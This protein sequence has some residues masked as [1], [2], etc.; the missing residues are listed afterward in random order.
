MSGRVLPSSSSVRAPEPIFVDVNQMSGVN[1]RFI[2]TDSFSDG[3]PLVIPIKP[4]KPIFSGHTTLITSPDIIDAFLRY[5]I[6]RAET[7]VRDRDD[8]LDVDVRRASIDYRVLIYWT[9][10]IFAEILKKI[11]VPILPDIISKRYA[12]RYKPAEISKGSQLLSDML[13]PHATDF[14]SGLEYLRSEHQLATRDA[15]RE[16][17][18]YILT[19]PG[20]S[21]RE[22]VAQPERVDSYSDLTTEVVRDL[23][24]RYGLGYEQMEHIVEDVASDV[25]AELER[26]VALVE[27]IHRALPN[28][29]L[30]G[31]LAVRN[32]D[33]S[34]TQTRRDISRLRGKLKRAYGDLTRTV[35][36]VLTRELRVVV[37]QTRSK[38]VVPDEVHLNF[39]DVEVTIPFKD[40]P[41]EARLETIAT[42]LEEWD[43]ININ[44]REKGHM[45]LAEAEYLDSLGSRIPLFAR[46]KGLSSGGLLET[47]R[48]SEMGESLFVRAL[49][50]ANPDS[51]GLRRFLAR[52]TE[53]P[54]R[55]AAF[56][57]VG[58]PGVKVAVWGPSSVSSYGNLAIYERGTGNGSHDHIGPF[59]FYEG[60]FYEIAGSECR[61]VEPVMIRV[62]RRGAAGAIT[63]SEMRGLKQLRQELRSS[64][65]GKEGGSAVARL[66]RL[67]F[68]DIVSAWRGVKWRDSKVK[69]VVGQRVSRTVRSGERAIRIAEPAYELV[70]LL[71]Q[72]SRQLLDVHQYDAQFD[73][74]RFESN[75]RDTLSGITTQ[76]EPFFTGGTS[77]TN[78]RVLFRR[79]MQDLADAIVSGNESAAQINRDV[80]RG[81]AID[82][83]DHKLRGRYRGNKGN[84]STTSAGMEADGWLEVL[85]KGGVDAVSLDRL[86]E[87]ALYRFNQDKAPSFDRAR[88]SFVTGNYLEALH[89]FGRLSIDGGVDV[90]TRIEALTQ[91]YKTANFAQR[92]IWMQKSLREIAH[93]LETQGV[94][95]T[96]SQRSVLNDALYLEVAGIVDIPLYLKMRL[97]EGQKVLGL[98]GAVIT[99]ETALLGKKPPRML[100]FHEDRHS[101]LSDVSSRNLDSLIVGARAQ[102]LLVIDSDFLRTV[103]TLTEVEF[104]NLMAERSFGEKVS[105]GLK[106][107]YERARIIVRKHGYSPAKLQEHPSVKQIARRIVRVSRGSKRKA[108][109]SEMGLDP[110]SGE[111]YVYVEPRTLTRWPLLYDL[112]EAA[113]PTLV[114]LLTF[115][116]SRNIMTWAYGK[117][118]TLM[119]A[120]AMQYNIL[121]GAMVLDHGIAFGVEKY[122]SWR[123][124]ITA[125]VQPIIMPQSFSFGELGSGLGQAIFISRVIE[126]GAEHVI[127][128]EPLNAQMVGL[129]GM[130]AVLGGFRPVLKAANPKAYTDLLIARRMPELVKAGKYGCIYPESAPYVYGGAILK[131]AAL[132][133]A[134]IEFGI[135]GIDA[136]VDL[137]HDDIERRVRM[138]ESRLFIHNIRDQSFFGENTTGASVPLRLFQTLQTMIAA[139]TP[140]EAWA[141]LVGDVVGSEWR[142]WGEAKIHD[143]IY[144]AHLDNTKKLAEYV[145]NAFEQS[146]AV[147]ISNFLLDPDPP[148]MTE[149]ISWLP[150]I[151]GEQNSANLY[152]DN[153]YSY[154]SEYL[155]PEDRH[156]L[157][158]KD[159]VT[160]NDINDKCA[161]VYWLYDRFKLIIEEMRGILDR[162]A[163]HNIKQEMTY[164]LDRYEAELKAMH[165]F[166]LLHSGAGEMPEKM[167]FPEKK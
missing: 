19:R 28:E 74:A 83:L 86:R 154:Q 85:G 42:Y 38:G 108:L 35:L 45:T 140:A 111:F 66:Y 69:D 136:V 120:Q 100:I 77:E 4:K 96:E 26:K 33:R 56:R 11:K 152:L 44:I 156:W 110:D 165:D 20:L 2:H 95:L 51:Q 98:K 91:L 132:Y 99:A 9:L 60:E 47:M 167:A 18:R 121:G 78:R 61:L 31:E 63:A 92:P 163:D 57:I 14:I 122:V 34:L 12:A 27:I 10:H 64:L 125:P 106:A 3:T 52:V 159:I 82:R 81:L 40:I 141:R 17:V 113:G 41:Q 6:E 133:Y 65:K 13:A 149:I 131:G 53:S 157:I 117:P 5:Q 142:E 1:E 15:F 112:K 128:M 144:Q 105:A 29:V 127:G 68:D 62:D 72:T 147:I 145:A 46:Y 55:T 129:A 130:G 139:V 107:Y 39:G 24:R 158:K 8:D 88:R 7:S 164:T 93:L 135:A 70:R 87:L 161:F 103:A 114:G 116:T 23:V 84:A 126:A 76:Y 54:H 16:M 124:G 119:E 143:Q 134:I 118:E 97:L 21:V 94:G 75:V 58:E 79:N 25:R 89:E 109:G 90:N 148:S 73:Q 104:S 71:R 50:T 166:Y 30:E 160:E 22:M 49:D 146:L 101:L 67:F 162:T 153:W 137:A 138:E 151:N 123:T 115:I 150:H 37:E 80:I 36:P 43:R 32:V 155:R 102:E 59:T 48:A